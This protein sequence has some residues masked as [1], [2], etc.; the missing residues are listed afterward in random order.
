KEEK[1]NYYFLVPIEKS[2]DFDFCA[3]CS[4]V[5]FMG[6]LVRD[7]TSTFLHLKNGMWIL[8]ISVHERNPIL[9]VPLA[10]FT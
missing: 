6:P 9:A 3:T 4:D 1:K 5:V 7:A 2:F 10:N 8:F